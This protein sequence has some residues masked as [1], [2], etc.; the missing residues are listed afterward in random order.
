MYAASNT[1]VGA[2]PSHEFGNKSQRPT[3]YVGRVLTTAG[4]KYSIIEKE[5]LIIVSGSS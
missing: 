1:R 2:I 5:A 4:Q 3:E